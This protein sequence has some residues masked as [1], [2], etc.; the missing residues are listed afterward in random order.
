MFVSSILM[1]V[2][3]GCWV[4]DVEHRRLPVGIHRWMGVSVMVLRSIVVRAEAG[5]RAR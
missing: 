1:P 4:E 5:W 3:R 2:R